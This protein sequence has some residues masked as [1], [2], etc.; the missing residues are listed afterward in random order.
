MVGNPAFIVHATAHALR[1]AINLN[2]MLLRQQ[3]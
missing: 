3:I 1:A 2:S